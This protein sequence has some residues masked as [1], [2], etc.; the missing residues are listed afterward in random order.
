M[1]KIEKHSKSHSNSSGTTQLLQTY[2]QITPEEHTCLKRHYLST[3]ET[4]LTVSLT[5]DQLIGMSHKIQ[6][7]AEGKGSSIQP[8]AGSSHLVALLEQ[9]LPGDPRLSLQ[10][11]CSGAW[12]GPQ[13]WDPRSR[14]PCQDLH[15]PAQGSSWTTP[16]SGP[17]LTGF[18]NHLIFQQQF[19]FL[20]AHKLYYLRC[21]ILDRLTKLV[22]TQ[23]PWCVD[24]R[25]WSEPSISLPEFPTVT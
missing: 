11:V 2:W 16:H 14:A 19:L 25:G 24:T 9:W 7:K 20:P 21:F 10:R 22:N 17:V 15:L 3:Q 18:M 23:F 6:E 4:P 12:L 8:R 1:W 5:S 13:N